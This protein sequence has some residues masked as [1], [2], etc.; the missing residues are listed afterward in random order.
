M[1]EKQIKVLL[2][3]DNL[4]DA[5]LVMHVFSESSLKGSQI[6]HASTLSDATKQMQ[7]SNFDVILSDLTLPDGSG[8][9]TFQTITTNA[10]STP[11]V[12]LTVTSDELLATKFV[13]EGAQD[14]LVKGQINDKALVRSILYSIERHKQAAQNSKKSIED[15]EKA[16]QEYRITKRERDI[17]VLMAQGSTNEGI[18]QALH[19]SVSTVRNQVGKILA[20]L[21]FSNRAQASAFAVSIGLAKQELPKI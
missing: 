2:I 9:D 17:L 4:A 18:G 5:K 20:K 3:E 6:I 7:R 16:L 12:F 1:S 19:L 11:L 21:H 10:P 15:T 8:V 14:Y 13:K